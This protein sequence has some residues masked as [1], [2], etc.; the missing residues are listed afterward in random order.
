M[1]FIGIAQNRGRFLQHEPLHQ[2]LG[3]VSLPRKLCCSSSALYCLCCIIFFRE[4]AF[5]SHLYLSKG[6]INTRILTFMANVDLKLLAPAASYSFF[7]LPPSLLGKMQ[8]QRTQPFFSDLLEKI[9]TESVIYRKYRKVYRK[10]N[11]CQCQIQNPTITLINHTPSL[12]HLPTTATK[13]HS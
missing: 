5:N 1:L 9:F 13:V 12:S 7:F 2:G 10:E 4:G 8:S 3:T 11:Q 6:F